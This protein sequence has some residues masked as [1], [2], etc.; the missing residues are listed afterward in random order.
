MVNFL[1]RLKKT[2]YKEIRDSCEL[3]RLIL[4]KCLEENFNDEFVCKIEQDSFDL[5]IK[6]YVKRKRKYKGLLRDD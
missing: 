4:I 2:Y 5:C 3:K 1:D 6:T